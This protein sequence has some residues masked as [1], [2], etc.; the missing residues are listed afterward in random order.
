MI[1]SAKPLFIASAQLKVIIVCGVIV[2]LHWVVVIE[3]AV[4]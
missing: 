3:T 1:F 2:C 4:P